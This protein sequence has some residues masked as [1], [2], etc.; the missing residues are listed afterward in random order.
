MKLFR[1]ILVPYDFSRS[2]KG[3]LAVGVELA[4]QHRG[5]LLVVNVVPR[6]EPPHGRPL[7]PPT[8]EIEEVTRR[9]EA[10]VARAVRGRRIRRVRTRVG[11][12]PPATTI[13]ELAAQAD[14]IVMGTLGRTGLP[15]V[16]IGSV[17]ERVVRH[18]PIPVLTVRRPR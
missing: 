17:A 16:L 2:A 4:A 15:R 3:A 9:L 5:S 11:I 1:R 8:T 18:S 12:G 10:D 14:M 7:P 6:V 13:L